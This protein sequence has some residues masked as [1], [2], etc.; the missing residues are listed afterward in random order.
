MTDQSESYTF[1]SLLDAVHGATDEAVALLYDRLEDCQRKSGMVFG[2]WSAI[3]PHV[4]KQIQE[5]FEAKD[6][7]YS[8]E[9]FSMDYGEKD[10]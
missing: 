10:Q 4:C 8:D 3:A 2:Y 5:K 6:K 7:A 1:A 9:I